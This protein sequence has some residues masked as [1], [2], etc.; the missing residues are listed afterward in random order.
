MSLY[1]ITYILRPHL[2][3]PQ[4]DEVATRFSSVAKDNGA[5]G[6]SVERMG[7]RRLAY[8]I[9]KT[10][11]GHYVCMHFSGGA[12]AANEVVRQLRLNDDVLRALLVRGLNKRIL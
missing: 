12:A 2:E 4:V 5:D 11:E 6:I 1:E 10:R 8:E 3:D 7:K 9:K